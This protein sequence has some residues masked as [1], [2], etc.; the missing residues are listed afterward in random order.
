MSNGNLMLNFPMGALPAGRNGLSASINLVYNSKQLDST[1]KYFVKEETCEMQGQEPDARMVCE[2]YKRTVLKHAGEQEGGWRL[3]WF[4]ALKL[5]DRWD[6]LSEIP[7]HL[8]PLCWANS[9][10]ISGPPSGE[11]RF[12]YKLFLVLPD[13]SKH[14]MRPS[15]YSDGV[16]TDPLADYFDIR[17]DGYQD[18]CQQGQPPIWNTGTLTYYSTDGSHL[19]LDIQHDGNTQFAWMDNPWTLY[20]PDGGKVT[21][22]QPNEQWQR[23]Y[24][25]NGNYI[26]LLPTG[27]KD[28]FNRQ[29]TVGGYLQSG[30]RYNT[31]TTQ[32]FG[33]SLTWTIRYENILPFKSYWPCAAALNCDPNDPQNQQQ[34]LFGEALEVVDLITLPSQA[35]NLSYQFTYNAPNWVPGQ[36]PPTSVGWGE[37]SGVTLPSGATISYEYAQDGS[38]PFSATPDILRNALTKKTLSYQTQYDGSSS[39]VTEEWNY[40]FSATGSSVTGP[41]G[42]TTINQVHDTSAPSWNSGLTYRTIGPDDTK[43]ETDWAPNDLDTAAHINYQPKTVYTSFKNAPGAQNPYVLTSIKDYK[44]DKNGNVTRV[45]EYDFIPYSAV[46]RDVQGFPPAYQQVMNRP[47]SPLMLITARPR[48]Q[49]RSRVPIVMS[50]GPA[51]RRE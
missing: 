12:R 40:G 10:Q 32:G 19:R 46:S 9:G 30:V 21:S 50:T 28:Q 23:V 18:L 38:Q 29:V 2:M 4:Y 17:P 22:N 13:G 42:G 16:L 27:L 51:E 31:V 14:E 7:Q 35:G 44:Y 24:D 1:T 15:G 3:N 48:T 11:L 26:E 25:R 34:A 49:A 45:A 39:N 36:P 6:E 8:Q 20:L 43:T 47:G 37:L 41:D 33:Q 5:V